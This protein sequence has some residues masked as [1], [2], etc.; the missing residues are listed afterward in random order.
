M[1][2]ELVT[3][4]IE[5]HWTIAAAESF[6]GGMFSSELTAVSG[7]SQ[8]FKGS[9]V[10]YQNEIKERILKVET[11]NRFGAVS[12]ETACAM[13]EH[14]REVFRSDIGISF[15]GN[16]GPEAMEEKPVGLVYIAVAIS[17]ADTECLTLKLQGTREEIRKVAIKEAISYLLN[18][19]CLDATK[20]S[21]NI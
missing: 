20:A 19:I 16:A 6:T 21:I 15:T 13:A 11:L 12:E 4:L 5:E 2:K 10:A 8:V 9:I 7:V 1:I 3:R 17:H 18:L 14:V